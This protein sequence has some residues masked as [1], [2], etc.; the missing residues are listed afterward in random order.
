MNAHTF[1]EHAEHAT[2][3]HVA[4]HDARAELA[5]RIADDHA[6]NEATRLP[7]IHGETPPGT[8]L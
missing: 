2:D 1:A 8:T 4:M 7:T 3:A 5:L 6:K